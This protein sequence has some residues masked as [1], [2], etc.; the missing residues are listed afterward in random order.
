MIAEI[1]VHESSVDKVRPGQHATITVEAFPDKTFHGEVL[2][3]APLPDPQQGFL[4]PDVKVYTTK[5]SIDGSHDFLRPGM[6]AKVV[7]LVDQLDDVLIVPIQV[8]ANREGKKLC[9]VMASDTPQPREVGTG[10]FNDTFVEIISGLE[11]GEQV[12]LNPP[13]LLEPSA[14]AK[15]MEA[16]KLPPGRETP[17]E[18]QSKEEPSSEIAKGANGVEK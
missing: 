15:S 10:A 9:Y 11:E 5:V 4:S 17:G 16:R 14:V 12:L 7:I 3:V 8:V 13:R 18:S 2:N 6:S 1:C